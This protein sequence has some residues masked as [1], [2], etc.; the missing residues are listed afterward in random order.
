[1][2]LVDIGEAFVATMMSMTKIMKGP[3]MKHLEELTRMHV[4]EAIQTG[5]KGQ[6]LH[7]SLSGRKALPR[8]A[9]LE[10]GVRLNSQ[11]PGWKFRILLLI[12]TVL[13][14]VG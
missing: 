10:K 2:N 12:H 5:L 7:R 9:S 3:D 11:Q 14:F 13:K 8:P 1:M 6:A 4:E